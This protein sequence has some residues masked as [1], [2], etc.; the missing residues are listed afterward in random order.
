[1]FIIIII[2]II[3]IVIVI[4]IIITIG[5]IVI[6]VIVIIITLPLF[7]LIRDLCFGRNPSR[8]CVCDSSLEKHCDVCLLM[9]PAFFPGHIAV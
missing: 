2:T 6:I 7:I 4:I 3:V 9:F 5:V 1:M 8:V